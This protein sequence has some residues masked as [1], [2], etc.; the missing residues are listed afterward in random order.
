MEFN[1]KKYLKADLDSKVNDDSYIDQTSL[2]QQ[3]A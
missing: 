3:E 1:P 2:K